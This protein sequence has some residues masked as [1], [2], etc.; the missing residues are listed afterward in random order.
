MEVL[1]HF[2]AKLIA[3]FGGGCKKLFVTEEQTDNQVNYL[4]LK[5]VV[6][7]LHAEEYDDFD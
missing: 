7:C 6:S 2:K 1:E 5:G 3:T 4:I